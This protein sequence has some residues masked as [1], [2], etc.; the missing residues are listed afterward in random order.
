MSYVGIGVYPYSCRLS[1]VDNSL[2]LRITILKFSLTL[3]LAPT[4]AVRTYDN[5]LW[6]CLAIKFGKGVAAL[7]VSGG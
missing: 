7:S 1:I 2:Y 3:G 4:A 5:A 6:L